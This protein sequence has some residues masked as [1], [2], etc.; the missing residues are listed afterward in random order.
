M[1][2][3]QL[4]NQA[5]EWLCQL[6]ATPRVSREEK[7]AADLLENV[8][9]RECGLQVGRQGNNLWTIAPGFRAERPTLLLNAHIDTVRPVG[10]WQRN[11]FS[12]SRE[13]DRIYGLGSNDDGAS[14]VS[15]MQAFRVLSSREQAYNL[16][17]LASAEEEVSGACGIA[18]V[19]PLLPTPAVALVGEPTG[20][21]PAIAERG[22]M[23]LDVT[24]RGR[25]GHAARQEGDNA[26]Y[27][28]MDDIEWFRTHQWP[29]V[30]PLL[31]PVKMTVT[32]IQ[33]GTQHNVIPDE[34]RF[35]VDVRTN[36]HYPNEALYDLICQQVKSEVRARSFRLNSSGIDPAHPLVSR[37][38]ALGGEPFG[39]PTL[40]DQAQMPF[41]SMK[42]G[43]GQ[44]SRSHTA[45]EFIT[46]SE[47]AEAISQYVSL[48][49]GLEI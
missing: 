41:P 25:A 27:R 34:C 1:D 23:V 22:L 18:S 2:K 43:P 14:L 38:V 3:E 7:Q 21:Q 4:K 49:D 31:G 28:A 48:L 40:S 36:E 20:M 42:M 19:L 39:S 35:T 11:P 45:D 15:L 5:A 44:S 26:I 17:F 13:G 33:A 6:I 30:S 10:G 37:A 9:T 46:E 16:V 29:L 12:P 8:M 32:I 24:A 47:I